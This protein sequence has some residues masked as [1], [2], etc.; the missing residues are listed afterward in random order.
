[1]ELKKRISEDTVISAEYLKDGLSLRITRTGDHYRNAVVYL[2]IEDGEP[3]LKVFRDTI[4]HYGI[5]EVE[6]N[7]LPEEW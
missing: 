4:D 3:V 2:K 6:D 1:M 5:K 7:I